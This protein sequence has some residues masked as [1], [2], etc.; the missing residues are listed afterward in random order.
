MSFRSVDIE[1]GIVRAFFFALE[2]PRRLALLRVAV[3]L[4]LLYD[5]I[6]HWRPAIELYS[7]FGPALP[8]FVQP[9]FHAPV[10]G[11]SAAV[12]MHSAL[13]FSLASAALGWQ[14]R[15]S[16]WAAFLLSAWLGP[17]DLA[18][19][20]TK[21]SVLGLHLLL[22]LGVSGCGAAWSLDAC[23][24]APSRGVNVGRIILSVDPSEGCVSG[25]RSASGKM[26]PAWP[27]RLIQILLCSV[28]LGAALTKI[29]SPPFANGDLLMYSLLDDHW[30]GGR[31]GL[32][33]ATLPHVP[34]LLSLATITF[35]MIFPCLIW[36][37]ACR[38]PL[39]ALAVVFHGGM[40]LALHVG[41][42][43]PLMVVALC[44]F[45]EDGEVLPIARAGGR[46]W[47]CVAR[48]VPKLTGGDG[49]GD[50]SYSRGLSAILYLLIAA[51]VTGGGLAF[52][53]QADDYG[54]FGRRPVQPLPEMPRD[55][56]EVMLARQL[57]A[58]E[59][60]F[61]RVE[62]GSRISGNQVFG[63]GGVYQAGQRVYVLAELILPHPTMLLE[64][65][66][67]APDGQEVARFTHRLNA[68][69]SYAINGFELTHE[70][71]PGQYRILLQAEG[72]EV[73]QRRFEL[74]Q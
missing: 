35:E 58:F 51:S 68:A 62:L 8:V 48:C 40:T 5:A 29:R 6:L 11:P 2:D 59:D 4:V 73:A 12:L 28:Y 3:C 16:L 14:T 55:E 69:Y 71:E 25:P 44:V 52:Q 13:V 33:L 15:L 21:Y 39:L 74:T 70:L 24:E 20:F 23:F 57:P 45:L 26:V 38:L 30:G 50:P 54:T 43:G 18:A 37:R 36:V 65:L 1:V 42:F 49:S 67:I 7:T 41:I 19:T 17:L 34:L 61:Q 10:P 64:G 46:I 66:L 9:P 60:Y 72:Y 53:W 63:G 32:W 22:L 47:E 27:R 31:F 56:V